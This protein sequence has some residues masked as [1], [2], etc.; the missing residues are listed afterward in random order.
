MFSSIIKF[1]HWVRE[2]HHDVF[3]IFLFLI[4]CGVIVYFIPKGNS[5][6]YEYQLGKVWYN[7]ALYSPIDFTITKSKNEVSSE[8]DKV[9]Q[10]QAQYFN[11][12]TNVLEFQVFAFYKLVDSII[13]NPKNNE[14][15]KQQGEKVLTFIYNK[16]IIENSE[17][18]NQSK[19]VYLLKNNQVTEKNVVDFFS[20]QSAYDNIIKESSNSQ[21]NTIL[22]NCLSQNVLFNKEE[23]DKWTR[24]A[25]DNISLARGVV[26]SGELIIAKGDIIDV[27]KYQKLESLKNEY[28]R[29]YSSNSNKLLI[30]LG[31]IMLVFI[32]LALLY[33]FLRLFR[34][35]IV[36]D[37]NNVAFILLIICLNVI[38]TVF[39][40]KSDIVN[41]YVVPYCILPVLMRVFFDTRTALFTHIISSLLIGFIVPNSFE[42]FLLELI[43]GMITIFSIVNMRNRSQLF[44]SVIFIFLA[45]SST[46]FA[47]SILHQGTIDA[48][49]PI[50][51]G[52]F[53][54]SCMITL[55]SYPL[56]Y[57]FERTFG[58]ISDISLLELTDTNNKLL[59]ALSEKAPG[60]FQH[61][62]HVS[63]LAEEAIRAIGG[64]TL[65]VRAGALYH[66]IGKMLNPVYFIENQSI[67]VN[68]HDEISAEES[69]SI[70]T[71][72]VAAGIEIA[73]KNKLPDRI[74]D[75][76]R[77]HHGTSKVQYFYHSYVQVH[78]GEEVDESLFQYP[79]P[80]PFS[81]ETAVLMMADG[82]EASSR[83]L[84]MFNAQ[85]IDALVDKIIDHQIEENQYVNADIT[86]KHINT[87]KKIFKKRLLNINH[88]RIEYPHG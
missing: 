23:T 41:L 40:L 11:M 7:G 46:Y 26:K 65:L 87:I 1:V 6:K 17:K 39:V 5:F 34:A 75:F 55:F 13:L 42:F 45:Y 33:L 72:H 66:D 85:T 84:K 59:R 49:E 4:A 47:L 48:V 43:A 56:I 10:N 54:I 61:S 83:S 35:E 16:G 60:T 50:F 70:I 24:Q 58:F 77:T 80:I 68:A 81:K 27:E 22:E 14:D 79:G 21:L 74:I 38:M 20:L 51:F 2:N 86:F 9:I 73:K 15:A 63:S 53:A 67:G 78:P 8:R 52:Y 82:V 30:L 62:L 69:A 37:N 29:Q 76:I 36:S 28:A 31:Q 12:D 19:S 32:C 57:I 44:I 3:K 25:I 18:Q 64:N 88:L 71:G